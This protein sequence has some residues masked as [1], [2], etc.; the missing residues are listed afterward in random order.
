MY[1][2]IGD[3]VENPTCNCGCGVIDPDCGYQLRSCDDQT[4]N[5][6]YQ[7]ITCGGFEVASDLM[8][9]RL[10]SARCETLPS[11]LSRGAV[12]E[13]KCIPDVYSELADNKTSLNDCDCNCGGMD[14][15]CFGDFNDIYCTGVFNEAGAPLPF[16]RSSGIRCSA[17]PKGV[18]CVSSA[19]RQENTVELNCPQL[20]ALSPRALAAGRGWNEP[21]PGQKNL[22][23]VLCAA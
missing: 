17:G 7:K 21:P 15:D 5:P 8:F 12:G 1:Y 9:C 10:E 2:E 13:W 23:F 22:C 11:G 3:G 6:P 19:A 4:W 18:G 20:P 14:P 16:L